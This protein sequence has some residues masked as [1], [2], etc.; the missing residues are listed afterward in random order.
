MKINES[1]VFQKT[2]ENFTYGANSLILIFSKQLCPFATLRACTPKCVVSA[3][4][5]EAEAD[6][7]LVLDTASR[8]VCRQ[9]GV[10]TKN[11]VCF[12]YRCVLQ[13]YTFAEYRS[14]FMWSVNRINKDRNHAADAINKRG[15]VSTRA[16][17]LPATKLGQRAGDSE[18]SACDGCELQRCV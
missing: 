10:P 6:S 1:I 5:R 8:P 13:L 4:R 9:A 12:N 7:V 2:P 14:C 17:A 16:A 3:R 15:V 18:R 11:D